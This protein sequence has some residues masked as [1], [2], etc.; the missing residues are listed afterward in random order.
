MP[1]HQNQV[2]VDP[3]TKT[4]S[5]PTP[6]LKPSQFRS[7]LWYQVKFDPHINQVNFDPNTKKMSFSAPTQKPSQIRSPH[8]KQVNFDPHTKTKLISIQKLKP[9]HFRPPRQNQVNSDPYNYEHQLVFLTFPCYSKTPKILR[10]YIIIPYFIVCYIVP[11]I[12]NTTCDTVGRTSLHSTP[13]VRST[14]WCHT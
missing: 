2:N 6:T 10:T 3:Y 8:K 12:Y 11:G 1:R 4:K 7:L 5:F 13:S 9:S 14:S